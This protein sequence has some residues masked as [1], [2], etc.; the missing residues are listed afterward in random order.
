MKVVIDKFEGDFAVCE[1]E[2]RSLLNINRRD[3]P[4]DA[5]EGYVLDIQGDDVKI[6]TTETTKRK[7]MARLLGVNV[8]DIKDLT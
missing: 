5:L 2:D 4:I 1:K 8:W 3:V 6:D 7:E